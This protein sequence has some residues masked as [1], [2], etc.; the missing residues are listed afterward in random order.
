[1]LF[2]E[3][4]KATQKRYREPLV[5]LSF[6]SSLKELFQKTDGLERKWLGE[7]RGRRG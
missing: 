2:L 1:M 6:V 3:V 5:S 7:K 4:Q